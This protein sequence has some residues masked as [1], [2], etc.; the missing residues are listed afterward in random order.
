MK[1]IGIAASKI[2][3]GRLLIY[4]LYVLLISFLFSLFV[5]VIAGA[6]LLVTL[7]LIWY[8]GKELNFFPSGKE[9]RMVFAMCM[10]F[11]TAAV[12]IF[13]VI[14]VLVNFKIKRKRRYGSGT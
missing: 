4:N 8:L 7:V 2:A 1:R 13:N 3:R 5:F 9:W 11:L 12:A 6:T 10:G 14:A